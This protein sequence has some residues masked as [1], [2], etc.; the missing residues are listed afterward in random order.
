MLIPIHKNVT[1]NCFFFFFCMATEC[2]HSPCKNV[3]IIARPSL[4]SWN[5]QN[6]IPPSSS[7][8]WGI[9][10]SQW[11]WNLSQEKYDEKA[12][13]QWNMVIWFQCCLSWDCTNLHQL[14]SLSQHTCP[15]HVQV[16]IYLIVL[17]V[18]CKSCSA[19]I[20]T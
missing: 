17:V 5:F 19:V 9:L 1:I 8:L 3:D 7:F 15:P 4:E 16:L 12:Y 2:W 13:V 11:S 20:G 6:T 18:I 14:L 10:V